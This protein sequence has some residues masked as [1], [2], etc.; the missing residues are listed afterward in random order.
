MKYTVKKIKSLL[1]KEKVDYTCKMRK[2]ALISL[3][4]NMVDPKYYLLA[5]TVK[6]LKDKLRSIKKSLCGKKSDLI[7]RIW[8][9]EANDIISEEAKEDH[10]HP[11]ESKINRTEYGDIIEEYSENQEDIVQI[12]EKHGVQYKSSDG[13]ETLIDLLVEHVDIRFKFWKFN[14][15]E[16]RA[17]CRKRCLLK[18]GG[19][20]GM[21]KRLW[22]AGFEDAERTL[23]DLPPIS[24]I[25]YKVHTTE[26]APPLHRE[27]ISEFLRMKTTKELLSD[28][29]TFTGKDPCDIPAEVATIEDLSHAVDHFNRQ[30]DLDDIFKTKLD[31]DT[32]SVIMSFHSSDSSDQVMRI[33]MIE[34]AEQYGNHEIIRLIGQTLE[35]MESNG[36][37][38]EY[39]DGN[40]IELR[41]SQ[42][43]LMKEKNVPASFP[44][45]FAKY[46]N[47]YIRG[48]P[49]R[50][51]GAY[52]DLERKM[53]LCM[54]SGRVFDEKTYSSWKMVLNYDDRLTMRQ[55]MNE[56][57][58][59][60]VELDTT[61]HNRI[62][63]AGIYK[64]CEEGYYCLDEVT[65]EDIDN[66][67]L[68]GTHSEIQI[69]K[70]MY[71]KL[72]EPNI[73]ERKHKLDELLQAGAHHKYDTGEYLFK[74]GN[75]RKIMLRLY[76]FLYDD[77]ESYKHDRCFAIRRILDICLVVIQTGIQSQWKITQDECEYGRTKERYENSHRRQIKA[78]NRTG[79]ELYRVKKSCRKRIGQFNKEISIK[80]NR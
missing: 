67:A 74:G 10:V 4:V 33:R 31:L 29:K 12:L 13:N 66:V 47:T 19:K 46:Y 25:K 50:F 65:Q 36:E 14:Q 79:A 5:M 16:L 15:K 55:R 18:R 41:R 75:F 43:F 62:N 73:E 48:D 20:Q 77:M 51:E 68:L 28:Y 60:R 24:P 61:T 8:K 9:N 7:E 64:L 2:K 34:D 27:P 70:Y 40:S 63:M 32:L 11:E 53:L 57:D 6:Q 71:E 80:R 17:E 72:Y 69:M 39:I 45:T 76:E 21:I 30:K 26:T 44:V 35:Q 42:L 38:P 1:D 56:L 22:G 3:L 49:S 52:D 23:N 37:N 58:K 59:L 78:S 54:S